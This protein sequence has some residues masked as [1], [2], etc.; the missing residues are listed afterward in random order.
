MP[1][2]RR[3]EL[4]KLRIYDY[5]LQVG[6]TSSNKTIFKQRKNLNPFFSIYNEMFLC[7]NVV[8]ICAFEHLGSS[9]VNLN[10][11]FEYCCKNNMKLTD[12]TFLKKDPMTLFPR[13]AYGYF[14]I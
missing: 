4:E 2:I 12:K 1:L 9:E 8:G 11:K 6:A 3:N 14:Y 7:V 10:D 5:N 13:K